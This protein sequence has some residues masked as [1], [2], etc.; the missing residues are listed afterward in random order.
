MIEHVRESYRQQFRAVL[1]HLHNAIVACPSEQWVQPVGEYPFWQ[2]AYHALFYLDFYLSPSEADFSPQSFHRTDYQHFGFNV[3]G[4]PCTA[5][6]TYEKDVLL[7]YIQ[8]CRRKIDEIIASETEESLAGPSGFWWYKIPRGEFHLNNI[9]HIQHHASQLS[10]HLR[11]A[12]GIQIDWIGSGWK[13]Q[14]D[15]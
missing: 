3:D 6:E 5:D 2:V 1:C 7:G 8:H 10:L 4:Q 14:T 12:A 11:R 9:R 15:G 13:E